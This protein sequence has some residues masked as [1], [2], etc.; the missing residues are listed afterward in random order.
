MH[1][2][3]PYE[4]SSL[5]EVVS[6]LWNACVLPQKILLK[7]EI[8]S[9]KKEYCSRG[10]GGM[11]RHKKESFAIVGGR[12]NGCGMPIHHG[13][14][15]GCSE[16]EVDILWKEGI[17]KRRGLFPTVINSDFRGPAFLSGPHASCRIIRKKSDRE[18][19]MNRESESATRAK[20]KN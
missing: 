16:K 12:R 7:D 10:W 20:E 1:H 14:K 8:F 17:T 5:N 18:K 13:R 2:T 9:K 6:G 4:N 19:Q 11:K 3:K 15:V